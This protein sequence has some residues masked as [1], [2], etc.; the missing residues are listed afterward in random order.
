MITMHPVTGAEVELSL[1]NGDLRDERA[2][3]EVG[4]LRHA[5]LRF[6]RTSRFI[7][8]SPARFQVLSIP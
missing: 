7:V 4:G 8:A 1:I 6:C 2:T 5:S 3:C